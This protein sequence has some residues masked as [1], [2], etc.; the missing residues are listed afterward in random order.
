MYG[1]PLIIPALLLGV[2]VPAIASTAEADFSDKLDTL[3]V[4]NPYAKFEWTK[5][6]G[7]SDRGAIVLPVHLDGIDGWF[8]LD[9]GLD[10]SWSTETSRRAGLA[11]PRRSFPGPRSAHRRNGPRTSL[12]PQPTGHRAKE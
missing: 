10:V 12:D 3:F 5:A 11:H 8:Q 4:G 7:V 1:L 2:S 9:T 6:E